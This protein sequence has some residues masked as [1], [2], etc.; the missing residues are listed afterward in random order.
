MTCAETLPL[1]L[2]ASRG[3]LLPDLA[4]EVDLHL[5]ACASC[6]R[7]WEREREL[8]AA[9]KLL[10]RRPLP[11]ALASRLRKLAPR[12]RPPRWDRVALVL[13]TAACVGLFFIAKRPVPAAVPS[14]RLV[15]EAVNDHLR[16]LLRERPVEVA[17]SDHHQ[18]KPWFAGRVDFAPVVHFEG[19]AE[20]PLVGGSV[21]FFVDRKAAVLSY[22][23][24]LHAISL[25]VLPASGLG[26]PT[27]LEAR[28]ARGFN[29][30]LWQEGDLAYALVSDLNEAE[31]RQL[32]ARIRA[33]E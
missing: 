1:I 6:Q 33:G 25:M 24:R 12:Q 29:L 13:A 20:F 23:R 7:Q 8:D 4:R 22:A 17:S 16:Q 32:A 28:S 2:D 30:L 5:G 14:Q 11:G 26:W 3:R 21:G 31:L 27:A 18:V 9:L 10:E 15:E 19:D